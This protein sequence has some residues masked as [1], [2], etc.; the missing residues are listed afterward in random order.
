MR[1]NGHPLLQ[2]RKLRLGG[3][4]AVQEIF[5]L[6]PRFKPKTGSLLCFELLRNSLLLLMKGATGRG[7]RRAG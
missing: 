3:R 5:P 2:P 7:E 4:G 1:A 6:N